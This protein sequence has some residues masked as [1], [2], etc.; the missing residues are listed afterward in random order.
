MKHAQQHQ[1]WEQPEW[2]A[3]HNT[4]AAPSARVERRVLARRLQRSR[5]YVSLSRPDDYR[6]Q[7]AGSP[8]KEMK[9]GVG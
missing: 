7:K 3:L 4:T 9:D 1:P 5:V 2:Y 8:L 6:G